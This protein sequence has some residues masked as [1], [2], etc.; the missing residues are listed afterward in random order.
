MT[1]LRRPTVACLLFILHISPLCGVAQTPDWGMLYIIILSRRRFRHPI[2]LL[3]FFLFSD[4]HSC[5]IWI[6]C[7]RAS[8]I[9]FCDWLSDRK[10]FLVHVYHLLYY[11]CFHNV[12][13][14]IQKYSLA[15]P[16]LLAWPDF[17][18]EEE[19]IDDSPQNLGTDE[20]S[21][22]KIGVIQVSC[23]CGKWSPIDADDPEPLPPPTTRNLFVVLIDHNGLVLQILYLLGISVSRLCLIS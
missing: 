9:L 20:S 5:L 12:C 23:S 11:A 6:T 19:R 14:Y 2:G 1:S 4:C 7:L 21:R 15:C 17:L 16:W 8:W 18:L 3:Y 22:A 13:E 10:L